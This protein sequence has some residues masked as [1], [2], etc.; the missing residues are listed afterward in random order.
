LPRRPKVQKQ[1]FHRL[2]VL[3]VYLQV[4]TSL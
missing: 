4:V 1:W 2:S 3:F